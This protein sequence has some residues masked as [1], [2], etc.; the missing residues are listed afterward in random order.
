M[1][2]ITKEDWILWSKKEPPRNMSPGYQGCW[3]DGEMAGYSRCMVENVIPLGLLLTR[4]KVIQE[5]KDDQG[6][7]VLKT[8]YHNGWYSTVVN[9]YST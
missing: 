4:P 1:G 2:D 9:H 7:I 3:L 6:R 8:T 5:I